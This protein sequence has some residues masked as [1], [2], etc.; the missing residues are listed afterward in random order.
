MKKFGRRF[1][2]E[3]AGAAAAALPFLKYAPSA[4]AQSAQKRLVIFYLPNEPI[5]RANWAPPG[6]NL[7]LRPIMSALEPF[8]E[9]IFML[10]D[11]HVPAS[12]GG[13]GH[14]A[15]A[16]ML[17]GR[18]KYGSG[19]DFTASGES[20]DQFIA[21]RLGGKSLV[22]GHGKGVHDRNYGGWRI[23]HRGQN[24]PV[25]P[26]V[27]PVAGFDA[28]FPDALPPPTGGGDEPPKEWV[29]RNLVLDGVTEELNAITKRLPATDKV[30]LDKHLT[31][32]EELYRD[33]SAPMDPP[34]TCDTPNAPPAIAYLQNQNFPR[35]AEL[36]MQTVAQ[37]M[38]C[39][40]R[41]VSVLQFG[42]TGDYGEAIWPDWGV[43]VGGDYHDVAHE[44]DSPNRREIMK[45]HYRQFAYLLDQLQQRDVLNDTVVFFVQAMT[46]GHAT[47]PMMYMLAGDSQLPGGTFRSFSGKTN[48]DVLTTVC[49]LMGLSDVT[50]F[51]QS[52]YNNG[53]LL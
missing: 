36:Q 26:L 4:E 46:A 39:G 42:S 24:D 51:G 32:I 21:R 17:T 18:D 35:V 50:S 19:V 6:T 25:S 45:F 29:K 37:A 8:R 48:N 14:D 40:T 38:A 30:R 44:G 5:N 33:V 10:G 13:S 12:Y 15:V 2:L 20:I 9:K 43:N 41:R 27:D 16:P 47:N 52:E 53:P 49:Q 1:L 22:L 7:E 23:V 34:P 28:A 11:L 3:G 31:G